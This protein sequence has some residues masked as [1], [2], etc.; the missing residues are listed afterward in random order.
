[1]KKIL[2]ACCAGLFALVSYSQ[3]LKNVQ[4]PSGTI[5]K[6]TVVIDGVTTHSYASPNKIPINGTPYLNEKFQTGIIELKNSDK[7]DEILMRYNISKDQF[8]INYNNDTLTI[9]RP[10]E[11]EYILMSDKKYIYDP[12]FMSTEDATRR[13]GY[14]EIIEEGTISLFIKRNKKLSYDS[15]VSNYGGGGGTKEYYYVDRTSYFGQIN[16]QPPFQIKSTKSLLK[17]ID[18]NKEELKTYIKKNK[19]KV[20]QESDIAKLVK[21]Y[22]SL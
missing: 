12:H 13:N 20:K 22:N 17:N 18:D 19:I 14:L 9:N 10:H 5:V 2:I 3:D 16:G 1:M 11:I 4:L 8:E 15:F 7:S 21:Y 6:N